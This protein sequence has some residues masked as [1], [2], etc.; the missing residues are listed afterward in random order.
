M[1]IN[2]EGQYDIFISYR[3]KTGANDARLLEQALKA[4]KFRV[5]FDFNSIRDGHFDERIFTA[6]EEASVFILVMTSE[7]LDACVREDD[8]VR[9]ELE[10]ALK[11]GKKI[12]PVKPSDQDCS[13]PDNLPESLKRLRFEQISEIN[14]GALFETSIDQIIQDR[15]PVAIRPMGNDDGFVQ[16][17]DNAY[18]AIVDF[19]D[20][21]RNAR[22][23]EFDQKNAAL[24]ICFQKIYSFYEKNMFLNGRCAEDAKIICDK[25]NAFVILFGKFF[26]YPG[27][28]RLSPEAQQ[29]ARK[30]E[31]AL[32]DLVFFM[33]SVKKRM[34]N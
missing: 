12:V 22:Q 30:A 21:V 1:R 28:E 27:K 24:T 20:A 31:N 11:L 16:L 32:K 6:I 23:Q 4:R 19:K 18:C 2:K 34:N 29:Y 9:I 3:R 26:S 25:Y 17:I 15:F 5:F 33:H 14:K 7:T 10:H 8:W 13:F